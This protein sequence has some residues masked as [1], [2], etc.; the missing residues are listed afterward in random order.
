MYS[1]SVVEDVILR[2]KFKK[3]FKTVEE[4]VSHIGI[5]VPGSK[6]YVAKGTCDNVHDSCV[7]QLDYDGEIVNCNWFVS[8]CEEEAIGA[9]LVHLIASNHLWS[10][11]DD[12]TGFDNWYKSIMRG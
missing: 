12:K 7:K 5:T 11:F 6:V 3:K 4:L 9:A 2:R 8:E 10:V 1:F